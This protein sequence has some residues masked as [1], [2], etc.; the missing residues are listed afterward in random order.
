MCA[1]HWNPDKEKPLWLRLTLV[2]RTNSSEVTGS[3]SGSMHRVEP[4]ISCSTASILYSTKSF[5]LS[6]NSS[7][8][9][10]V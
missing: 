1:T 5:T 3:S 2:V 7:R 4:L 9:T 6:I 10:A 8:S